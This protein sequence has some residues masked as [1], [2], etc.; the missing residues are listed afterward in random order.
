MRPPPLS[1]KTGATAPPS[2]GFQFCRGSAPDPAR[3]YQPL[4]PRAY[5]TPPPAAAKPRLLLRFLIVE[6][7]FAMLRDFPALGLA[8]PAGARTAMR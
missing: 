8:H 3:G 7:S 1:T 6:S 5:Q 2:F 4:R